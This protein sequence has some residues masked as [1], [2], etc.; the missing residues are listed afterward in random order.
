[1]EENH[2]NAVAAFFFAAIFPMMN[3]R[4]VI[5]Q[6]AHRLAD[7]TGAAPVN[8]APERQT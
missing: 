3:V 6:I 1:M 5:E 4:R 7:G 2:T 8:D